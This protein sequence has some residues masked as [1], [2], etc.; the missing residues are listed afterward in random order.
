MPGRLA[1]HPY[2]DLPDDYRYSRSSGN[3]F[4]DA[5][6]HR[7]A[8]RRTF[9]IGRGASRTAC[10]AER[11]T[12]VGGT[13]VSDQNAGSTAPSYFLLMKSFTSWL[14]NAFDSFSI[15]SVWAL[16]SRVTR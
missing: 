7:S 15:A 1:R 8:P 13:R 16:S 12:I 6:R 2:S 9:R 14:V 11:R 5:L 10:D 3:A 4:R